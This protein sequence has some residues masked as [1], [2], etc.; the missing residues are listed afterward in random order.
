VEKAVAC[1]GEEFGALFICRE[2]GRRAV[3]GSQVDGSWWSAPSLFRL[4][5]GRGGDSSVIQFRRGREATGA[6]LGSLWRRG[7]DGRPVVRGEDNG[8]DR[9]FQF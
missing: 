6:A 4:L 1:V 9:L 8:G 3:C 7:S 5:L 2:V